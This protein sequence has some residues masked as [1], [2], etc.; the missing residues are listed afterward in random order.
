MHGD[1]K[2]T[3]TALFYFFLHT[4][5]SGAYTSVCSSNVLIRTVN[6]ADS[7]LYINV[8]TV[9]VQYSGGFLMPFVNL[10]NKSKAVLSIEPVLYIVEILSPTMLNYEDYVVSCLSIFE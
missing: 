3:A 9:D 8:V 1:A 7:G 4:A 10:S 2:T 5:H 6:E